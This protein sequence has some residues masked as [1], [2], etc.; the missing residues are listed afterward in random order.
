MRLSLQLYTVRDQL[1]A[2]PLGTYRAIK[3]IGLEYVEGGGSFGAESAEEG[4]K[5]LDDCGLKASGCHVGLD[6]LESDLPKAIE[7][8]K[9][10]GSPFLIV[11]W[12]GGDVYEGGWAG[13][14]KRL[15]TIGRA[16]EA[17]GLI[18]AYHNHDFEFK[19]EGTPGLN[20]L[21]DSCDPTFVKSE[22][23]LAWVQIG[24]QDP[25]QYIRELKNRLPL[26]HLKD[27]DPDKD[28]RWQPAGQGVVNWNSCLNELLNS[29]VQ[30]GA[31]EL[32]EYAGDP[33]DAVRMSFD[34]FQSKGLQ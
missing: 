32:D 15:E 2:D 13:V 6:R 4:R 9:V 12:I 30:F 17:A 27:F 23:D 31:I 18:L 10:L 11:P 21:F 26:V 3:E 20:V 33:I 29:D 24:G 8:A 28:P 25:A 14:G 34:Y 22:L 16:V 5:M 19:N 1:T 7:E